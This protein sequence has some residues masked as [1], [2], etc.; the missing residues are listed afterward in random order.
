MKSEKKMTKAFLFF[1]SFVRVGEKGRG[2]GGDGVG[3]GCRDGG[4]GSL[5]K[6]SERC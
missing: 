4:S 5:V 2:E 1:R 6:F 3:R